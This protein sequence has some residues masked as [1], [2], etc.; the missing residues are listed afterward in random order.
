MLRSDSVSKSNREKLPQRSSRCPEIIVSWLHCSGSAT[1][2]NTST[3][4]KW[5]FTLM[6]CGTRWHR[7]M[8]NVVQN[9]STKA[10]IQTCWHEKPY[11]H[12]VCMV[13][14]MYRALWNQAND[15]V[16]VRCTHKWGN[17]MGIFSISSLFPSHY[18]NKKYDHTLGLLNFRLDC[19]EKII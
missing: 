5:N 16:H 11:H 9:D 10:I 15:D 3:K 8:L 7:S 18:I 13:M 2:I 12:I 6:T 19:G 4:R 14:S 17:R 1:K